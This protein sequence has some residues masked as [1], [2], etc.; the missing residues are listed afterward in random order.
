MDEYQLE[1]SFQALEQLR[2]PDFCSA[3]T[4]SLIEHVGQRLDSCKNLVI[5]DDDA[6]E[7]CMFWEAESVLP[8]L[9]WGGAVKAVKALV[10]HVEEET[11]SRP[12]CLPLDPKGCELMGL[13]FDLRQAVIEGYFLCEM[14][15]SK[16]T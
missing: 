13:V 4:S 16:R 8:C 7:Y 9:I 5:A 10:V 1:K 12:G 11:L 3:K 2:K 6:S 14:R 15:L